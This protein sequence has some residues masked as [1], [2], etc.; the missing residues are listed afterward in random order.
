[1][2]NTSAQMVTAKG[3]YVL[4]ASASVAYSTALASCQA[5]GGALPMFRTQQQQVGRARLQRGRRRR[6]GTR[7]PCR[8]RAGR[9]AARHPGR[10]A[11]RALG[12]LR[13][14]SGSPA[15]APDTAPTTPAPAQFDLE[16]YFFAAIFN[17]STYWLGLSK[18]D[19]PVSD[20]WYRWGSGRR[21]AGAGLQRLVPGRRARGC[22]PG[23]PASC[24][25]AQ[26]QAL[27]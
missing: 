1:V 27:G 6:R 5:Q 11:R 19:S 15:P 25:S 21:A 10:A 8:C 26:V 23:R 24:A 22:G 20:S 3:M 12:L 13:S 14:H 17:V 18:Y 7:A 9:S 2:A 16:K 4:D